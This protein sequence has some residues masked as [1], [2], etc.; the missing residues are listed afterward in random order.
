M[1]LKTYDNIILLKKSAGLVE[2]SQALGFGQSLFSEDIVVIRTEN[3]KS[4]LRE[5]LF[6][7]KNRK[8]VIYFPC[9]EEMFRFAL[10]RTPVD[11]VMGAEMIH[12]KDSVHYLR[13][14]IDQVLAS[15]AADKGKI[16]GFSFSEILNARYPQRL[17]ARMKMNL[18][19]CE[20]YKVK[21]FFGNFS[22]LREEIRSK[23]DLMV[24]KLML[25]ADGK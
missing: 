23:K 12:P 1:S 18:K 25:E 16:I 19:I 7:K 21:I 2:I 20:K 8:L 22:V 9:S 3:K 13:S 24:F 4:L 17:L 5:S 15:I 10:E 14:G 6:G 11:I